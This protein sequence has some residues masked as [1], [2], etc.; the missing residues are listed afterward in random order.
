MVSLTLAL[1]LQQ[2]K[3]VA[4]ANLVPNGSFE[5]ITDCELG[6]SAIQKA[7]PWFSPSNEFN[8]QY[9]WGAL[10]NRCVP[11]GIVGNVPFFSGTTDYQETVS[12]DG[13]SGIILNSAVPE[14][15]LRNY[16][17][18]QLTDT[19]KAGSLYFVSWYINNVNQHAYGSNNMSMWLTDTPVTRSYEGGGHILANAQIVAYGNPI[20]ADTQHWTQIA[21]V[22]QAQGTETA[23][24]IGDFTDGTNQ[25]TIRIHN[26]PYGIAGY[27]IDDVSITPLDSLPRIF[28][29]GP[30]T[31][32]FIGNSVKIGTL[33]SGLPDMQW[34]DASGNPISTGPPQISVSPMAN[35]WYRAEVTVGSISYRDTVNVAVLNLGMESAA[36]E[37]QVTI[38]PNPARG[39]FEIALPDGHADWQITITDTKGALIQTAQ[40]STEKKRSVQLQAAPGLYFVNFQNKT[41]GQHFTRK[42]V[43]QP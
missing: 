6:N 28:I 1:L 26:E 35:T 40:T 24:L 33:I 11:F 10:A 27:I 12:G 4:Q 38:H 20:I 13:Y 3:L 36:L 22:Y 5:V 17:G 9:L 8:D 39:V 42:L 41:S 34:W 23:I 19:L 14:N 15:L 7:V 29:A 31:S 30:D 32:V 16:I 25:D 37:K 21:A 18:T 43:I 2:G